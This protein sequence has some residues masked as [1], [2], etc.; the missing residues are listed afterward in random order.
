MNHFK[1][2][3]TSVFFIVTIYTWSQESEPLSLDTLV[4]NPPVS[5]EATF[6]HEGMLYQLM[7]NKKLKSLPRLGFFSI[8]SMNS[9]WDKGPYDGIMSQGLLTYKVLKGLDLV[10]G[11]HYTDVTG[12]RPSAGLMYSYAN[13]ETLFV[14]NPRID[15]TKDAVFETMALFE[16]KPILN[17]GWKM[18]SRV[19]GVYGF[20]TDSGEHARSYILARLGV[21][22]QEFTFGLAG[23]FDWYG[24]FRGH[25]KNMGVFIAVPLF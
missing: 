15:L 18:Y 21:T 4:P 12:A 20:S 14:I 19:Q 11:F 17:N 2:F 1:Y 8:T 6:A 24:P 23:N 9:S 13:K 10:A 25:Q 22:I 3:I 16:Y 5:L 7:I